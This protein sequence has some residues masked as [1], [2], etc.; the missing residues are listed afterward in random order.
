MGALTGG[1]T[2]GFAGGIR[3]SKNGMDFWSG[4]LREGG[5]EKIWE[6][7]AIKARGLGEGSSS[8]DGHSWIE[9]TEANGKTSS[10]GTW[11]NQGDQEFFI[12]FKH[13]LGTQADATQTVKIKHAQ[14]LRF[15]KFISKPRNTNWLTQ[16][17]IA[18]LF[19]VNR[20]VF[21]KHI[22][23]IFK[24]GELDEQVVCSNFTDTK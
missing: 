22:G 17:K 4:K 14:K 1:L 11:G 9:I 7:I 10:Y 24:S 19:G 12:N 21:T 15:D 2:G 18:D 20:T 13:D 6:E 5:D 8:T 23:N 3:A 16:Q